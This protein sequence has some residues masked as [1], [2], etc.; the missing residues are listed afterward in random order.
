[1][2]NPNVG[3]RIYND[4]NNE[5]LRVETGGTIE[6]ESGGTFDHQ[7]GAT[8]KWHGLTISAAEAAILDGATLSTDEL[9]R[10][11][12]TTL[13]SSEDSKVATYAADGKHT[14]ISGDEI[15][16]AS[17]AIRSVAGTTLTSSAI[18]ENLSTGRTTTAAQLEQLNTD[19][20]SG[21]LG[22]S[23]LLVVSRVVTIAEINAGH[24]L[25]AALAGRTISVHGFRA[26]VNGGAVTSNDSVELEDD[27]GTPVVIASWTQAAL[28]EDAVFSNGL[29]VANQ[30]D[31]T[32]LALTAAK[33]ISVTNTG[34]DI[35]V[36][37][38]ITFTVFYSVVDA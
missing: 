15:D 3:S 29:V 19:Q 33:G 27:N 4:P 20:V 9:N 13:G 2:S 11:D 25:V 36:A 26:V 24:V 30:T 23:A 17:G 6:V 14:V 38:S 16:Y 35:T 34:S 18:E 5:V 12:I 7:S 32:P 22:G 37:T 28:T 1:M 21:G 8:F 10:L 31:N